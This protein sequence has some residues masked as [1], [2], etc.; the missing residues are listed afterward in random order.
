MDATFACSIAF[1]SLARR[2]SSLLDNHN[3]R[4]KLRGVC[5]RG[6]IR[7]TLKHDTIS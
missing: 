4:R 3:I 5:S 6:G 1:I 2:Q 7:G